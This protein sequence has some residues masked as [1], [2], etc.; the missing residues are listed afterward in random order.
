D[1]ALLQAAGG[2]EERDAADAVEEMVR[3][4]V[5]E[6]VGNHLDFTHDRVRDVAYARL[7]LPRRRLLHRAVAEAL[8][9]AGP[10]PLDTRGAPSADPLDEQIERLAHHYTEADLAAPAVAYWQRAS[11]R[12]SARSAYVEAIAQCRKALELLESLPDTPERRQREVL[13]QTTLGPAL[14]ATRGPATPEAEAAYGRA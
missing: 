8:E 1:F 2:V 7:L 9:K 12:S 4:R 14:M 6:A 10:K 13:L 11:E 5:L 3:H